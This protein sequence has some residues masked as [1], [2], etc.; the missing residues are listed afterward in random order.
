[1]VIISHLSTIILPMAITFLIFT[2]SNTYG[3]RGLDVWI[4]ADPACGLRAIDDVD[5]CWALLYAIK[6]KKINVKGLSTVFGNTSLEEAHQTAALFLDKIFEDGLEIPVLH[7]GSGSPVEKNRLVIENDATVALYSE[8]QKGS[9]SIIALGPLTNLAILIQSHPEIARNIS[10]IVAVAGSR[11]NQRRFFIGNSNLIHFHDL[12]FNKDPIAFDIILNSDIPLTLV[13]FEV[14]TKI[15]VTPFDL[16]NM[17]EGGKSAKW[18]ADSSKGWIDFW[19]NSF[20]TEGFYPFDCLA[21]GY[22]IMPNEYQCE[23]MPIKVEWHYSTFANR[24]QLQVSHEL[25]HGRFVN[26]CYNVSRTMKNSLVSM[27]GS[28]HGVNV[29]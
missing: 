1:M 8:L 16:Q 19:M 14:A 24:N 29:R 26:Y 3:S 23:M 2:A 10:S 7:K 28:N 6:S 15:T 4:D 27:I 12:N 13:P 22:Q 9:M 20:G 18:L 21:V 17:S 5:D 25:H 11:K